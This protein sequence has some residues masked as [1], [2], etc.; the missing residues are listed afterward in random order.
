MHYGQKSYLGLKNS[1]ANSETAFLLRRKLFLEISDANYKLLSDAG[2]A[3]SFGTGLEF[4]WL[5]FRSLSA[6]VNL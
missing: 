6:S 1:T 4:D 5:R 3:T 2:I